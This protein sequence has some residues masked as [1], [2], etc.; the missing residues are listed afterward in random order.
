MYKEIVSLLSYVCHDDTA[1]VWMLLVST[2]LASVM[3]CNVVMMCVAGGE[4]LEE[5]RQGSYQ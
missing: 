1:A 4:E 3:S 2:V 5:L